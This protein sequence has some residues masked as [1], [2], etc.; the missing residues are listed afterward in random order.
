[1]ALNTTLTTDQIKH[2]IVNKQNTKFLGKIGGVSLQSSYFGYKAE[3][4]Y[5]QTQHELIVQIR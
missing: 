5:L 2:K 1:M 3:F 4:Y